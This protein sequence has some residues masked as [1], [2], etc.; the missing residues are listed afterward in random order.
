MFFLHFQLFFRISLMYLKF[1]LF[2]FTKIRINKYK[3]VLRILIKSKTI[4]DIKAF[5]KFCFTVDF[6]MFLKRI[7]AHRIVFQFFTNI[8]CLL[9]G[10]NNLATLFKKVAQTQSYNLQ[11]MYFLFVQKIQLG[12]TSFST[13]C[14]SCKFFGHYLFAVLFHDWFIHDMSDLK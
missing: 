11:H 9:F 14:N 4:V 10:L 13:F 1:S 12:K 3:K 5:W 8:S 2:L 7:F 6:W